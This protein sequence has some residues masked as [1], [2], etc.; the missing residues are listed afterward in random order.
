MGNRRFIL[1]AAIYSFAD[2]V[3]MAVGGFLLLPLYTR[4]LTQSEFGAYVIVR[5]NIEIFTSIIFLGLPSAV[6]RLYFDYKKEGQHFEYLSSIT[7]FFFIALGVF[8]ALMAIFGDALWGVLSPS[9]PTFPYLIFSIAISGFGFLAAIASIWLRMEG[10]V[11]V[12]AGMQVAAAII[13]TAFVFI[14]LVF[15][16]TGLTGLFSAILASSVF[17]ALP[18]FWLFGRLFRPVIE[19]EHVSNS[20]QY[21]I[22]IFIGY[23]A[24]FVL[25]RVSIFILQRHV[26]VDNI[27]VFGLAQQLALVLTIAAAS[28]GKVLQPDLFATEPAQALGA[29][30]R[31]G[32][33]LILMMFCITSVLVLFASEILTLI[34]PQSYS[35]GFGILLILLF[36]NFA[37][38]FTQISN[39]I[40]L[41]NRRTK[42][43][44]V[45]TIFGAVTT[46]LVGMWLV[47]IYQLYGAAI[48]AVSGLIVSA[49]A[50]YWMAHHS[51]RYSYLRYMWLT[52]FLIILL[53]F[54]VTW[55]EIQDFSFIVLEV[56]KS[57][58]LSVILVSLYFFYKKL[59]L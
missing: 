1:N 41:Y 34:A 44:V 7:I 35:G 18:L 57:V 48:G 9:I 25:N 17:S 40:L 46:A 53:G 11:V 15:R 8:I 37:Y 52:L 28:F 50:G 42:S 29:I 30:K 31:L 4:T 43:L 58:I 32:R 51:I 13:L 14:N 5:A 12:I 36:G 56:I 26:A 16:D 55:L 54:L 27:A 38:S 6:A 10:R 47:P 24:Y 19:W 45:V 21:A 3:V 23:T 2:L 39:A 20:L 49:Q 33:M 59:S 22:P